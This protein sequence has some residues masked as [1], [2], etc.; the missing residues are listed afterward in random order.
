MKGWIS[1]SAC[2]GME[3]KVKAS[4]I[5]AVYPHASSE[6]KHMAGMYTEGKS[7]LLIDGN[8]ISVDATEEEVFKAIELATLP[9]LYIVDR[10]NNVTKI[11]E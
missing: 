10:A 9:P 5:S 4:A 6:L 1:F 7:N 8:F 3:I 2:Q 11:E